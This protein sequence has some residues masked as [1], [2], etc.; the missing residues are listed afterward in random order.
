MSKRTTAKARS[1]RA[2]G[3]AKTADAITIDFQVRHI[4]RLH[5]MIPDVANPGSGLHILKLRRSVMG[6]LKGF[7]DSAPLDAPAPLTHPRETWKLLYDQATLLMER[8]RDNPML[9][10]DSSL[11]TLEA[12]MLL[13]ESLGERCL[14]DESA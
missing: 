8:G 11:G 6:R 5:H 9:G 1:T 10:L 12:Y 7:G 13:C 4:T 14:F 2:N 3:Q